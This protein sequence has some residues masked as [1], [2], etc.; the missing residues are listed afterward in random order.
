MCRA[1]LWDPDSL[2]PLK[3]SWVHVWRR[4]FDDALRVCDAFV[5]TSDSA[6]ARILTH[7]PGIDPDRFHVIPHGRSFTEMLQVRRR[8]ERG[9]PLKILVPGNISVAKGLGVIQALLAHD[10]AEMLEF[11]V[12]G[13]IDTTQEI[14]CNRL[15]D[16]GKYAR[17]AFA[18]RAAEIDAHLGAIFSIWDETLSLIHI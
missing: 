12:L 14:S 7:L 11:Q 16:H 15:F 1:E 5:T 8:P 18:A 10:V 2:P 13:T 17:G 3:N 6:R 4:L 9:Q